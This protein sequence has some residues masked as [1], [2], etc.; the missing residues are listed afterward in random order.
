MEEVK[1]NKKRVIDIK[2][3]QE[4]HLEY[5]LINYNAYKRR[6]ENNLIRKLERK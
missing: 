4:K 5:N 6:K 2:R 3:W 1:N